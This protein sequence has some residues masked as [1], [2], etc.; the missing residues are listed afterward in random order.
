MELAHAADDELV[1]LR[2][3]AHLHRRVFL[4]D[5][6]QADGNLLLV[7]AVLRLDRQAE[8]RRREVRLRQLRGLGGVGDGVAD[9]QPL[10]LGDRHDV[11]R[12][13]VLYLARRLPLHLE[14]VADADRLAVAEVHDVVV[15]V[16]RA[17]EDADETEVPD[18]LVVDDLEHLRDELL[19]LR[20]LEL[21]GAAVGA[22][23]EAVEPLA[24]EARRQAVAGECVEQLAHALVPLRRGAEDRDERAGVE[25]AGDVRLQLGD[26]D[27]AL[28]QVLLQQRLVALDHGLD[29][30]AAGVGDVDRAAGRD[31]RLRVEQAVHLAH[32]RAG[33]VGDVEQHAVLAERLLD[34]RHEGRQVHALGVELVDDDGARQAEGG[35][36]LEHLPRRRLDAV[37][38]RHHD[39]R[40]LD[41]GEGFEGGADEVGGAG[42]V[43]DVEVLAVVVGVE[44]VGVD[45][46]V[47]IVL[48]V[49]GVG[50]RR[51]VVHAPEPVDRVGV[52]EEGVGEGGLA[53]GPVPHECNV[54]DVLDQVL[55]RHGDASSAGAGC[56]R[57][58]WL[59]GVRLAVGESPAGWRVRGVACRAR[60]SRG[61]VAKRNRDRSRL[62]TAPGR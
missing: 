27:L 61:P 6:V 8:H 34:R 16:E 56:P 19:L 46:E 13:G 23:H 35:G 57:E 5:L 4:R 47:V 30:L 45:A 39:D 22:D 55:D 20:R 37:H 14:Q 33:A 32:P 51:P 26:R 15:V 1:R 18:E 58:R 38:R 31:V 11:A 3:V 44:D 49:V 7:A 40:R 36:L 10:D 17:G 21:V 59:G 24:G 25:R 62:R 53:R 41:R 52:E 60:R 54:A 48:L 12:P 9:L 42:G 2:V 28:G 43:E 29:Q 50:D